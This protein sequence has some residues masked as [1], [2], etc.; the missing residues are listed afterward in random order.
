MQAEESSRKLVQKT[1]E[2]TNDR[3]RMLET[4]L[5]TTNVS[6]DRAVSDSYSAMK[7]YETM[8]EQVIISCL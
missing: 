1:L 3:N 6:L 7:A 2:M 5:A 4:Q 8:K